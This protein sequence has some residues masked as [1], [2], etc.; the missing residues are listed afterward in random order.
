LGSDVVCRNQVQF[1]DG[2]ITRRTLCERVWSVIIGTDCPG[3][4]LELMAQAFQQIW[5]YRKLVYGL[6]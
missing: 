2:A 5:H 3:L 4:V 1:S 6:Q